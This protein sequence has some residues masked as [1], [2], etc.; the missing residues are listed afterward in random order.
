MKK[1]IFSIIVLSLCFSTSCS[2][3]EEPE[4]LDLSTLTPQDGDAN[5][6]DDAEE[7]T[8]TGDMDEN[9]EEEETEGLMGSFQ[10]SAHPTSGDVKIVNDTVIMSDNFKSDDGPDLYIYLAQDVNGNGFIDL[11]TLKST[12]GVQE[13]SVP[14][15][16]DYT[17]N[18]YVMVWCKKFNVL[19]GYAVV[20]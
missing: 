5:A 11:G 18:K 1:I 16:V 10:G 3:N 19:F 12:S 9:M 7:D 15:G 14:A 17:K 13:Y 4:P 2:K 20:E 8:E 6:N